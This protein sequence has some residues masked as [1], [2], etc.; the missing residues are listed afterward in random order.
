M[1]ITKIYK[2]SNIGIISSRSQVQLKVKY[3]VEKLESLF[4]S[5]VK[6]QLIATLRL[7]HI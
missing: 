2:H 1:L 3:Y 4:T 5:A 6:K 7:V